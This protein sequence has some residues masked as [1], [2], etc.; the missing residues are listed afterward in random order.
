MNIK[1]WPERK[2]HEYWCPILYKRELG[3]SCGCRAANAM[4]NECAKA[5]EGMKPSSFDIEALAKELHALSSFNSK[6]ER[7]DIVWQACTDKAF[8]I[9]QAKLLNS[10]LDELIISEGHYQCNCC[11]C[12]KLF[13]GDKREVCCPDC[14]VESSRPSSPDIKSHFEANMLDGD[15]VNDC[16][17]ALLYARHVLEYIK[18]TFGKVEATTGGKEPDIGEHLIV[19]GIFMLVAVFASIWEEDRWKE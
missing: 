1:G 7:R 19:P 18:E 3:C 17:R 2:D 6:P 4:L 15:D 10:R 8:Y 13:M 5:V 12:G 14:K 9:N 16:G 11:H